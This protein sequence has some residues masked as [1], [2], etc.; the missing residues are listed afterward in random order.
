[1]KNEM[2]SDSGGIEDEVVLENLQLY[3][4]AFYQE[5]AATAAENGNYERAVELYRDALTEIEEYR[6]NLSDI[7]KRA[8]LSDE[9]R[10][11]LAEMEN[12][13]DELEEG[14]QEQLDIIQ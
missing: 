8:T 11:H 5:T 13:L 7:R 12:D 2:G 14:V 1:M 4:I 6:N 3:K 9:D 10:E